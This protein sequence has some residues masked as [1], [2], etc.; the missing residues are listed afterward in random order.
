MEAEIAVTIGLLQRVASIR[1]IRRGLSI[2]F[3]PVF[4]DK[5]LI[6][7]AASI[8]AQFLPK[9][10]TLIAAPEAG[11]IAIAHQLAIE[12]GLPYIIVRKRLPP[13]ISKGIQ[14]PVRSVLSTKGEALMLPPED[15]GAVVGQQVAIVDDVVSTGDTVSALAEIINIAGGKVCGLFAIATQGERNASVRALCHLPVFHDGASD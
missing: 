1:R 13:G 14:V 3:L 4:G 15:V 7:H 10:A 9:K 11:G 2:A 12:S 5:E 6:I 8:L